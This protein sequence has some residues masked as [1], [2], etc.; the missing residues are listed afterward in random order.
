MLRAPDARGGR[1]D[2]RACKADVMRAPPSRPAAGIVERASRAA[3]RTSATMLPTRSDL[4]DER[5]LD[6]TESFHNH[7]LDTEGTHEQSPD[8]H[9]ASSFTSTVK[10]PKRA[11]NAERALM[12]SSLRRQRR[13]KR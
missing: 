3:V 12:L 7:A 6:P 4:H 11:W 2:V 5:L 9:S 1:F 13:A 8:A 10:K